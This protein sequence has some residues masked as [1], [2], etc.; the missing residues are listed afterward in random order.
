[1]STNEKTSDVSI[2][3]DVK[4]KGS[5]IVANLIGYMKEQGLKFKE[6]GINL[7]DT[8]PFGVLKGESSVG[9]RKRRKA[10]DGSNR[11]E[12]FNRIVLFCTKTDSLNIER[13]M[14]KK[15]LGNKSDPCRP[16]CYA[17]TDEEFPTAVRILKLNP[18]NI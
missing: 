6:G 7:L 13:E 9:F 16:Y 2:K 15:D 10:Q 4:E 11:Y 5:V 17:F 8:S 3:I 12:Q 14:G 1:M 18:E